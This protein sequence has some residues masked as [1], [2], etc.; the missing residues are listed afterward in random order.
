MPTYPPH[1]RE[2][3]EKTPQRCRELASKVGPW[4]GKAVAQL[5]SD[6]VQDRLPSVHSLLRLK[7][8]V[9][10]ER[11][12]AAC[13]RAVHY[14]DP[15]YI[16]VK[17]ILS[18]GLEN[19]PV[20]EEK[21]AI[22]QEESYR[23]ARS[24]SSYFPQG[25][26]MMQTHPLLPKLKRLRLG[27]MAYTLAQRS[28]EAIDRSLPPVE[29]LALLVDDE[30]E[31]RE[32]TKFIIDAGIDESKT[33]ARFDFAAAPRLKRTLINELSSCRFVEKGENVLLVGPT[34]TGKS[35]LAQGLAYEAIKRGYRVL[36]RPLHHLIN[37][38][39]TSRA[40]GAFRKVYTNILRVDVLILDDFGLVPLSTSGAQDTYEIIRDRYERK[41]IILTSNRAPEEWGEVF[42]NSLLASAALDRLTHHS[43]FIS[44]G[45]VSRINYYTP[46]DDGRELSSTPEK[47]RQSRLN[48]W[49]KGGVAT[50]HVG[51]KGR[52][53]V[54]D[55]RPGKPTR[56]LAPLVNR[57]YLT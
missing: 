28:Q 19:E 39:Y 34:G 50:Q 30:I 38:L 55:H 40:D 56:P 21:T 2:W 53:H 20:D 5:L 47:T 37:R 8:K 26:E 52:G 18:A 45:V 46:Q 32:Q 54:A 10:E 41:S 27:G 3:L 9:G 13:K 42:G 43:H 22:Q 6:R 29:F 23:Y 17:T 36:Y 57:C 49:R 48:H 16:R 31:R 15:R 35:H 1:K 51:G 12:E 33:I 44:G 14:G 4:C 25:G 24:S 7:E 11:L